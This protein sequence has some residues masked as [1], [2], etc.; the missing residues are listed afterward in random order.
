MN[1]NEIIDNIINF[2]RDQLGKR[3]YGDIHIEMR[4]N[5]IIVK[6]TTSKQYIK[7]EYNGNQRNSKD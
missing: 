5:K 2:I 7:E 6:S 4:G 1:N 3:N